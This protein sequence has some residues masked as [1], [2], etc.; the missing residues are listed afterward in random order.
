M[1]NPLN[2]RIKRELT[3]EFGKYLVIFLLMVMSIGF[4]SGFLVADGSMIKA[5]DESFTKYNIEDG[6]FRTEKKLNKAAKKSVEE[7]GITVYENFYVDLKLKNDSTMRFFKN[8]T[9]IDLACLMQGEFP[10]AENEIAIDRMYADNNGLTVGDVIE[11]EDFTWTVTGLVA[12]S[13]YSCLFASNNDSMFDSVKFGVGVVTDEGFER[14]D[15]D[16]LQYRYSWIYKEKPQNVEEENERADDLMEDLAKEVT[17]LDFVPA[18]LN[19]A[20][21]FTGEDMGSDRVMMTV[22]LYILIVIMAFVFG[23]TISNTI[24]KEA[25]VIGTLRASGYTRGELI[26]HYMTVPILVT[27]GGAILGNILGYTV[28]K[29]VCVEMY[30][31]SYSLPTYVTVWSGDAFVMTTVVPIIIMIVINFMVLNDKLK[32]SPL[33]FLRRNLSRKTQRTAVRLS[34]RIPFF[35]RFR[36]R[37]ILQN[38]SN[39]LVLFVGVVFANLL[40]MF[41]LILPSILEHY[42]GEIEENLLC[43]HQYMLQLPLSSMNSDSKLESL[44]SMLVFSYSVE[45]ENEDAE[46][47]SAYSL[48]TVDDTIPAEEIVLYGVDKNSRYIH[49][50]LRENNVY[51]SSGF[52]EKYG[53][54][55]GDTI[56]LKEKYKPD[57]YVFTITGIYGYDGTLSLF[58]DREYLNETFDYDKDFFAGYFC[59]S[60]ITDIDA[61]YIGSEI[62]LD[63]LTKIS[64]QL[65][66]SMGSMMGLVQGFAIAIYMILIYLLSKI[67]IEKNS[68]AISM[69]KILGYTNGEIAGLYIVSTTMVVVVCLLVSIPLC[70]AM[71]KF[72]YDAMIKVMISGWIPYYLDPMI[73]V[74]MFFAGVIAYGVV[75]VPEYRRIKKVPM[76]AALKNVE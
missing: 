4:V 9:E 18:Y 55:T 26:V 54:K 73:P 71:M 43:E 68:H 15:K 51:I 5:Y 66:V 60:A 70:A 69:T 36:I 39:Y 38:I 22:L 25:N 45:T 64:R 37:V 32:L 12:L 57:T 7:L 47:F 24:V 46:K 48:Q 74:K 42:Q 28:F 62:N 35:T 50:E 72:I 14:L 44:V 23:V 49:Q 65:N 30:Y 13:D 33:R 34:G 67:I 31:S 40:L 61:K 27:F 19:Q 20:I 52:A 17:L 63:E 59:D 56:L 29:E 21:Q 75:A 1:R 3:G 76:D 2:R 10:T 41:G 6:Q 58:M 11:G 53:Y 8:R 16:L